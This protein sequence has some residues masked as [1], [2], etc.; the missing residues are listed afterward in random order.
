M[1]EK[2]EKYWVLKCSFPRLNYLIIIKILH[3]AVY[4]V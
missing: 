1:D 2:H 3:D 4:D